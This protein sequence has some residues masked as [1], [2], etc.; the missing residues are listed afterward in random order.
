MTYQFDIL[1]C[2]P[3]NITLRDVQKK[4]L[5]WVQNNWEK[6]DVMTINIPVGGG[7]SIVAMTVC[8]WTKRNGL[9][10]SATITPTKILQDQYTNDFTWVPM[11]KGMDSYD[12]L[13][14]PAGNCRSTKRIFKKCCGP[15]CPYIVTRSACQ[16]AP[17]SIYNFHSYYY[18]DMHKRNV[19]IDEA[20][21]AAAFLFDMFAIKLWQPEWKFDPNIDPTVENVQ[22]IIEN[23]LIILQQQYEIA[24]ANKVESQMEELESEINKYTS[25]EGVLKSFGKDVLI[26]KKEEEYNG[27]M[28][29]AAKGTKQ[30]MIHVKPLRVSSIADGILWP[31]GVTNKIVLTSAT[32]GPND[33]KEL[34]LS[35]RKCGYFE[36][37]SP[38]PKER[39][40]FIVLPVANMNYAN[41]AESIPVIAKYLEV[42]AARHPDDKG[43]VHCTYGVAVQLQKLLKGSPRFV[44]HDKYNKN[45]KYLD[46]RNQKGNSIL[47]ASGMGE[48]VDLP[49][50]C[51]RWQVITKVQWPSL[52][53][54][55]NA[56]RAHNE[57]DM[58]QWETVRTIIQQS[59]RIVRG[60]ADFGVTYMLDAGFEKLWDR[61][62]NKKMW[63]GW[64]V[65]AITWVRGK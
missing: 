24:L 57:P 19:V 28:V 33:V 29:K 22:G 64:F 9:G 17:V 8:E 5:L 47:V 56:Y 65:E 44:F 61:T 25:V 60:P 58:Y 62:K 26:V 55:V 46:F 49:D 40:P 54:D 13:A 14:T 11:L 63:P 53:D 30:I 48:G 2:A 7:K 10:G 38:I 41:Q 52:A 16:T 3:P 18:N 39:R 31:V 59:G 50:D 20:H 1:S 6:L 45:Q 12:C 35:D 23:A 27:K 34:G 4:A 36:S 43:L 21:N 51:A 42:L 37:E 15:Q 32:I